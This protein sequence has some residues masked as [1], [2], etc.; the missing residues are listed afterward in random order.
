MKSI[1]LLK[2][3]VI[4]KQLSLEKAQ[5][6]EKQIL[7]NRDLQYGKTEHSKF[8][9]EFRPLVKISE[10]LKKETNPIS[11]RLSNNATPY[12]GLIF[13]KNTEQKIEFT[14][15]FETDGKNEHMRMK[16]KKEKGRAPA[17]GKI[18]F[19]E[20]WGEDGKRV[21]EFGE[22]ETTA[23]KINCPEQ[24]QRITDSLEHAY[25][26]KSEK[27]DQYKG[28]WLC[29]TFDDFEFNHANEKFKIPCKMFWDNV[30]QKFSRV[31][32]I[33]EAFRSFWDSWE[34]NSL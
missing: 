3:E 31:F 34:D 20:S 25:N 16:H 33:G 26:N 22:S 5:N 29:M 27:I 24:Y 4:N 30:N 2:N 1:D 12:D 8:F 23:C 13:M 7:E 21:T 14:R 18:D 15:A 11:I 9:Y 10:N 32:V 19:H 28:V 17:S 6:I